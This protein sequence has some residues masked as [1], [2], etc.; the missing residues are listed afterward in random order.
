MLAQDTRKLGLVI[1]ATVAFAACGRNKLDMVG[2]DAGTTASDGKPAS[3]ALAGDGIR[4]TNSLCPYPVCTPSR[5]SLI[6][7]LYVHDHRGWT[8]HS[9]LPPEI[10]TFPA[11]LKKAGYRTQAVGKIN[12]IIPEGG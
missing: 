6:S 8:N 12:I 3:D 5:Y 11:I 7:G 2:Q 9:T 10:E 1:A 4:F